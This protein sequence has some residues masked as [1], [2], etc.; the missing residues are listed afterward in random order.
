[1]EVD[2]K[3]Y[4]DTWRAGEAELP[5]HYHFEPGSPTD[6]ITVEIPVSLLGQL[7]PRP[8]QWH[9]AGYR[10]ELVDALIRTLPK[11]I[12]RQLVPVPD[13]VDAVLSRIDPSDGDLLD[14]L[15]RELRPLAGQPIPRS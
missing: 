1:G 3:D 14:P 15:R 13:T 9:I 12:R 10:A 2:P 8:F 7:D 11:E 5:L 6:G 4:P